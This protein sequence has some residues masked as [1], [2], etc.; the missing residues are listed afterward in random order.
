MRAPNQRVSPPAQLGASGVIDSA[1]IC[2]DRIADCRHCPTRRRSLFAG[3][4][5]PDFDGLRQWVRCA[6]IPKGALLYREEASASAIY[7]V[8]RGLLKLIKGDLG[9]GRIVRLLG[10]G[11]AAGLEG[12]TTGLY[13][14]SA[15]A[16]WEAEICRIPLEVVNELGLRSPLVS[17]RVVA[18]WEQQIQQADLWLAELSLG[19]VHERVNRLLRLLAEM[20]GDEAARIELPSVADLAAILGTTRES[21]SRAVADLKRAKALQHVAP[22]TY[23]WHQER[24]DC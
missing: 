13:R 14:H 5:G 21:V 11:A 24:A 3:L 2:W 18:Q 1:S 17:D 6:V 12:L 22:H 8:S 9:G 20:T 16:V 23:E 4:R 7:A 19:S 10:R 15:V